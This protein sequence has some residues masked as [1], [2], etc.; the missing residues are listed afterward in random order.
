M[1]TTSS[2]TPV[3]S[4]MSRDTLAQAVGWGHWAPLPPPQVS[5]AVLGTWALV[6]CVVL[7]MFL[8]PAL[9]P[10]CCWDVAA[11]LSVPYCPCCALCGMLCTTAPYHPCHAMPRMLPSAPC[12]PYQATCAVLPVYPTCVVLPNPWQ[13]PLCW[14]ICTV[15]SMLCRAGCAMLCR[16]GCAVPSLR[17]WLCLSY[18]RRFWSWQDPSWPWFPL[19]IA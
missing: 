8:T 3:P 13:C 5:Q 2:C 16:A 6:L 14:A 15:V 12:H 19:A 9:F 11:T 1:G 7:L 18:R 10:L 17:C 4:Q